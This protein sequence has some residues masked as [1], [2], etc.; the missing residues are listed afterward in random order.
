MAYVPVVVEFD[1]P[2]SYPQSVPA[3]DTLSYEY[4]PAEGWSL[5]SWGL[6]NNPDVFVSSIGIHPNENGPGG[7]ISGQHCQ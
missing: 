3:N 7:T 5:V 4:F 2:N 6:T 1:Y